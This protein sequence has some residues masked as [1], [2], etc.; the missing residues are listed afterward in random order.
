[1]TTALLL[2]ADGTTHVRR[3]IE[4]DKAAVTELL[5]GRESVCMGM[6]Y[7]DDIQRFADKHGS[8]LNRSE[9]RGGGLLIT[10]VDDRGQPPN[11]LATDLT[12]VD[13]TG[14]VVVLIRPRSS[15]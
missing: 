12:S 6:V 4:G 3:N 2:R 8:L 1:M 7:P 9:A 15:V 13:I 10:L 14:D 5:G 11:E